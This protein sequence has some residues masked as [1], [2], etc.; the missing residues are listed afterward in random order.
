MCCHPCLAVVGMWMTPSQSV[1]NFMPQLQTIQYKDTLQC[2][3]YCIRI[4]SYNSIQR[5]V[6]VSA[7]YLY[8][9]FAQCVAISQCMAITQTM[10]ISVGLLKDAVS[11]GKL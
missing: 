10:P 5:T 8:P 2:D 1:H 6:E 7:F 9:P 3:C 4:A 11:P